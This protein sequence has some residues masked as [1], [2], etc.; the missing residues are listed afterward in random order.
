[1]SIDDP[2]MFNFAGGQNVISAYVDNSQPQEDYTAPTLRLNEATCQ[3]DADMYGVGT[4][5]EDRDPGFNI[6]VETHE[7]ISSAGIGKFRAIMESDLDSHRSYEGDTVHVRV[8]PD[9]FH[10][11]DFSGMKNIEEND[12]FD[13]DLR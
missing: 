12:D 9:N 13:I 4:V 2:T 8:L 1:M 10:D 3:Y 5:M 11:T 7:K 6:N